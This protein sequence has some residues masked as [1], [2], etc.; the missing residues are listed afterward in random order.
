MSTELKNWTPP[1][2]GTLD[3]EVPEINAETIAKQEEHLNRDHAGQAQMD[4][5]CH[6]CLLYVEGIM[7]LPTKS[8]R[9]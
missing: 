4:S 6:R 5:S 1:Y 9:T 3:C 2:V 7:R 8:R